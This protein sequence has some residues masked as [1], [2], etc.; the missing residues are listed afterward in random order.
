VVEIETALCT[1]QAARFLG[2]SPG[3]LAVWRVR[4]MG[5]PVHYSGCKPVYYVSELRAW[6][7]RCTAARSN[8]EARLLDRQTSGV[9]TEST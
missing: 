5:P 6:Q 8:R 3:T 7:D 2:V 1:K 9:E 4:I